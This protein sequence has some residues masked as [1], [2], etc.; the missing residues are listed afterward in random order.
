MSTCV[1]NIVRLFMMTKGGNFNHNAQQRLSFTSFWFKLVSSVIAVHSRGIL[2]FFCWATVADFSTQGTRLSMAPAAVAQSVSLYA[3]GLGW[4]PAGNELQLVDIVRTRLN[5]D[6]HRKDAATT[7]TGILAYGL[8]PIV[9][10]MTAV[11][12]PVALKALSREDLG[13]HVFQIFKKVGHRTRLMGRFA[14]VFD[15]DE[16]WGLVESSL[17]HVRNGG[18]VPAPSMSDPSGLPPDWKAPARLRP[19]WYTTRRI[20]AF[21][22]G[23]AGWAFWFG[24]GSF[25]LGRSHFYCYV[26]WFALQ[27]VAVRYW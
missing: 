26:L 23:V 12:D 25:E 6:Y 19:P 9:A 11:M 8:E 14:P 22:I 21:I 5:G 24:S 2:F 10:Y 7:K 16:A 27:V 1:S 4:T 13:G 15:S 18:S 17:H 20:T 3:V